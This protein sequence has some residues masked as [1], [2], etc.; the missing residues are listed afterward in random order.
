VIIDF[1]VHI[2]PPEVIEA[3]EKYL[4]DPVFAL[5]YASPKSRMAG[6]RDLLTMMDGAGIDRAVCMAFPWKNLQYLARENRYLAEAASL[7]EGR[8]IPFMGLPY[9]C[10]E[11]LA[12]HV[13]ELKALGAA[14]IGE[15]A[16]YA[17]GFGSDQ[18]KYC[19]R[20]FDAAAGAAL[21]VCL[22]VNEPVGHRY[23]G[24]YEPGLGRLQPLLGEHTAAKIILSHWGGGLLFYE[25]MPEVRRSLG[26]VYYD[27]A[28]SPYIYGDDVYRLAGDIV[29]QDKILFGTDYP[30]LKP[31]RYIGAIRSAFPADG[32]AKVLGENA[33]TILGL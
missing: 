5:L 15:V 23:D 24:K 19:A 20:L 12:G 4:D 8:I 18:E 1:H 27:T 14:G 11:D 31:E 33:R 30:L 29:G 26:H 3:R 17:D 6:H 22:H 32:G 10:G 21:P 16:F 13:I 7:S 2:F 28:A 9:P 25:L